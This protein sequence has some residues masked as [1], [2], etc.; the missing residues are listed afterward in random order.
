MLKRVLKRAYRMGFTFQ[1]YDLDYLNEIAQCK[2]FR[3]SRSQQHCLNH[4]Y[5]VKSRSLGV[6]RLKT[7]GH[8]FVLQ[9]IKCEFNKH[10]FIV[11]SLFSYVQY[12]KL[13][14][15]CI[16]LMSFCIVVLPV[17]MCVCHLYNKLTYLL[18]IRCHARQR[19]EQNVLLSR[20]SCE[21]SSLMPSAVQSTMAC[22]FLIVL[23][24]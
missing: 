16:V 21:A 5:M 3:S 9:T 17:N 13:L 4:L 14:C 20:T 1:F 15:K 7:R 6:M 8:D 18:K 11:R 19:D 2:L 10:H 24:S 22:V 12:L 23:H